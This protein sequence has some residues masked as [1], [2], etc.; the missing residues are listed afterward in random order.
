[1]NFKCAVQWI[2]TIEHTHRKN[3]CLDQETEHC[4]CPRNLPYA[5]FQSPLSRPP[6][7]WKG[8][9]VL[10]SNTI[11]LINLGIQ[12]K[13]C[14]SLLFF[15]PSFLYSVLCLWNRSTLLHVDTKHSFHSCVAFYCMNIPQIYVSKWA[16]GLFPVWS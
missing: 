4:Q 15:M 10:I 7:P 16:F 13:C 11:H 1:M 9:T 2:V 14:H 3:E 12:H 6:R 8:K 5:S